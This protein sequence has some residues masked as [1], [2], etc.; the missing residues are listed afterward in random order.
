MTV[1]LILTTGI[2][3]SSCTTT[4]EPLP[5]RYLYPTL[6]VVQRPE[7]N[8]ISGEEFDKLSDETKI[9]I[10]NNFQNI[11]TYA[12]VLEEIINKYNEFATE[13]NKQNDVEK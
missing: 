6:P 3:T 2:L 1:A 9:K 11:M 5:I 13:K 8:S 4:K 12:T 10:G 7:L